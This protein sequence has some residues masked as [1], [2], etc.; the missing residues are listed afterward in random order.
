MM[1]FCT[2]TAKDKIS[3]A[4]FLLNVIFSISG[5][6]LSTKIIQPAE[7]VIAQC[8]YFKTVFADLLLILFICL[9]RFFG[10]L[11]YFNFPLA[12]LYAFLN[13]FVFQNQRAILKISIIPSFL[14]SLVLCFSCLLFTVSATCSTFLSNQNGARY[15]AYVCCPSFVCYV[16]TL[17]LLSL[18]F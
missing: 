1:K 12:F 11:K 2:S 6:I 5:I 18:V 4:A 7:I 14:Y 16:S 3:F 8:S 17:F 15:I 9:S 13:N 10:I